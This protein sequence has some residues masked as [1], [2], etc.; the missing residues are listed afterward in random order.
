M[1][2][3]RKSL[4]WMLAIAFSMVLSS[5]YGI[6]MDNEP[7]VLTQPDD[8]IINAFVTGFWCWAQVVDGDLISTG[9]PNF[10]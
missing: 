10:L 7:I 4:Y 8:V 3:I 6:W 2:I 5:L 1:K 9:Y